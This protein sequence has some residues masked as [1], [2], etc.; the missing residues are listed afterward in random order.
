MLMQE[1][2]WPTYGPHEYSKSPSPPFSKEL[3]PFA[4]TDPLKSYDPAGL[5][6]PALVQLSGGKFIVPKHDLRRYL[7]SELDVSR[8]NRINHRLWL[9]GLPRGARPLHK[10]ILLGRKVV[11]TEQADLHLVWSKSRIFIKPLPRFLLTHDTWLSHLCKDEG[12]FKSATGFLLS[13]AWL[14]C[15]R[16]DLRIAH[17][18]GLLPPEI[19]WE[20][21]TTFLEDFLRHLDTSS[22][23]S[24]NER[25]RFGE[26][27]LNRLNWIYR[28]S[29]YNLGFRGIN[30]GYFRGP[31]W[32]TQFLHENFGW[33]LAVF[34]YLSIVLSAMQVG[35]VTD[36]LVENTIFQD[37]SYGF[38][39]LSITMPV[40]I[41]GAVFLASLFQIFFNV[42]ATRRYNEEV[43]R[44]QGPFIAP[45]RQTTW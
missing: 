6:L 31:E 39:V 5:V 16:S 28:L 25:Y 7:T 15:Y 22:A 4:E 8:L 19:T 42:R 38:S 27:R 10:Q 2:P 3:G 18:L 44:S 37:A 9:A 23:S 13:Y 29:V 34:G 35:L 20:Q 30:R 11:V 43:R 24:I 14:V 26:L 33:L 21:W 36:K 12:L 1:E 41:V 45:D 17:D 32:Y 40:I